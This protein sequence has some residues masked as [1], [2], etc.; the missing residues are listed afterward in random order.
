MATDA[1]AAH[2]KAHLSDAENR[3]LNGYKC[4]SLLAAVYPFRSVVDFGC[5]IG[6]W[7]VAAKELGATKVLGLEGQWVTQNQI[8]IGDNELRIADLASEALDF[9]RRFDVAISIEVAE[10]LPAAAADRLCDSLTRAAPVLLFS[11]ATPGQGGAGHINEQNP[12]YWVDRLWARDYMPLE[13]VRPYVASDPT[14]YKWLKR[15]VIGFVHYELL[16]RHP[17]LTRFA[18]P[19]EHFYVKYAPA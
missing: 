5:G 7:L 1:H 2:H 17:G 18:L 8:L 3:I 9:K 19:R 12:R 15:N 16:L 10:H 11:A 14:V 4:L 13:L 6:G